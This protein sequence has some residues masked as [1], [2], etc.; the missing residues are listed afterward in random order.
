MTPTRCRPTTP[1]GLSAGRRQPRSA[2]RDEP[3]S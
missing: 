2:D 3:S 1:P